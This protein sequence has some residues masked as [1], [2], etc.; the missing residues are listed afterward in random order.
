MQRWTPFSPCTIKENEKL[1]VFGLLYREQYYLI[2][3]F[4]G[5]WSGAGILK[6]SLTNCK[7]TLVITY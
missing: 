2:A 3:V 7:V 5:K 4:W 6:C 1:E